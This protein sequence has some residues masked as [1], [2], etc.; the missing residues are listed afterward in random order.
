MQRHILL[1]ISTIWLTLG[2]MTGFAQDKDKKEQLQK[3]KQKLEQNIAYQKKLLQKTK[4]TKD[5]SL[6]QLV[7]LEKKINS[8]KQL[9]VLIRREV[10]MLD[11][12][13]I[14]TAAVI[15]SLQN[16]LVNLKEEYAGIIR[17][18]YKNRSHYDRML[19]IFSSNDFYQAYRRIR[20]LQQYNE[21]KR[22][23][24]GLIIST[25]QALE[26]KKKELEEKKSEKK[27][28]LGEEENQ[29]VALESEKSEQGQALT[30]LQRQEQSLR[31]DIR[32]KEAD[33]KKLQ[34]AIE[35]IIASEIRERNRFNL[36]PEAQ[37]LSDNFEK[38]KGK[39]PW[40]LL[41]GE[42][43]SSFGEHV[44]PVLGVKTYNNGIDIVT[45]KGSKARAV[46]DGEV[47][48]V[49]TVPGSGKAVLVRH[50]LY[51]TVY[52]KLEEV[53]VQKGDQIKTKQDIGLIMNNDTE[54]KTELH[55]EIRKAMQGGSEK[56]NPVTWL[57]PM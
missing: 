43:S 23:Q 28:L 50:G 32:R 36:T 7:I 41:Q 52:S 44:H 22:K 21:Y 9:V 51:L 5:I 4:E 31:D 26:Q 18:A 35:D 55:F 29:R 17:N 45:E 20:Y 37:R 13:I 16:D 12:E 27:K 40:P 56:L 19:F 10:R 6:I 53:Y 47:T 3:E 38:N 2:C 48:A 24:A 39:L 1:L 14:E 8:R 57:F 34:K 49:I 54:G 25:Q 46:F 33:M 42:I 11:D 15:E 30:K